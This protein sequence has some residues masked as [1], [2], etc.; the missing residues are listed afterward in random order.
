[1][2][3]RHGL[4]GLFPTLVAGVTEGTLRN[5]QALRERQESER[6]AEPAPQEMRDTRA[7]RRRQERAR[8]KAGGR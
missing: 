5:Q 7:E 4:I 3:I 6:A 1:M 2:L 8:K